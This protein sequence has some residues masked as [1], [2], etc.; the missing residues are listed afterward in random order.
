MRSTP[1]TPHAVRPRRLA[2]ALAA[3]AV[4]VA[5]AAAGGCGAS[6]GAGSGGQAGA[7]RGIPRTPLIVSAAASLQQAFTAYGKQFKQADARFS[8]AGS[9]TLEAQILEGA[10]PDLIAAANVTIPGRLNANGLVD[11]PIR[12]ASNELV[13][14]VRSDDRRI[15]SLADVERKGVRLAIGSRTVPVGAYTRVVLSNLPATESRAI[16]RNVRS[17]EPDVNGIVGKLTQGAVDAGFAYK[18]DVLAASGRLRIVALPASVRPVVTYA[19]AVVRGA[20]HPVQAR[21]F[22]Y[23]L[24]AGAGRTALLHAG[25]KP[26]APY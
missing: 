3:V 17:E 4:A 20:P 15:R 16:L 1:S 2:A 10:K 23:G 25:F 6:S 13:L 14:A 19:V 8:F 11:T 9:D 24:I 12:F 21:L 26:P 5:G 7:T 18:T 22:I